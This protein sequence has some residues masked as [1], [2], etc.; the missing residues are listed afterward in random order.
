MNALTDVVDYVYD[1]APISG[2]VN[3][4]R[5]Y[6]GPAVAGLRPSHLRRLQAVSG[7]P[8]DDLCAQLR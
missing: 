5:N 3:A 6:P 8:L 7:L 2:Q 4:E 1:D